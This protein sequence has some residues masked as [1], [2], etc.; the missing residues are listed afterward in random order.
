[1]AIH[2]Q[3]LDL[4][5]LTATAEPGQN[6]GAPSY[7]QETRRTPASA[8]EAIRGVRSCGSPRP[9]DV[10]TFGYHESRRAPT[11]TFPMMI[12]PSLSTERL[13]LEPL[14]RQHSRGMFLLWSREEVCRY[15]GPALDWAGDP[16]RLPARI[17]AESDKIIEFF[18][19]AA[20]ADRGFRWAVLQR[21]GEEF[22]GSVGFNSL[23]P[24]A[25]LAFHLRPEFWGLGLM[26]EAAEAGLGWLRMQRPMLQ[27][28]AFIEPGNV[29]SIRLAR[30]LGFQTTGIIHDGAERYLLGTSA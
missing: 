14:G 27:V 7:G 13:L 17:R 3:P 25:G 24:A 1:M 20:V 18:E 10:H 12:P 5:R 21:E 8:I 30:R 23:S 16:I 29:S 9:G 11:A 28:E 6:D 4:V 19:C 22:V 26:R 2:D 15:S